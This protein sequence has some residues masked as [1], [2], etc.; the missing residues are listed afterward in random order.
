LN[1]GLTTRKSNTHPLIR[2][3][4]WVLVPIGLRR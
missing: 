1:L 3:R 2:S 4:R